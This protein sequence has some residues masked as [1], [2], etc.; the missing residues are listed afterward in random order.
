MDVSLLLLNQRHSVATL[1]QGFSS[2]SNIK[3]TE[4][5]LDASFCCLTRTRTQTYK[6]AYSSKI[7]P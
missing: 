6:S 1:T 5:M 4:P 2:W 7:Y 3:S